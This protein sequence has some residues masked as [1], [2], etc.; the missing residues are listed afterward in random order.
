[1]T[2]N[3]SSFAKLLT[4]TSD[5][6]LNNLALKAK[7]LT[8]QH[9]GNTI[10]LYIPLYLSNECCNSCLYCGF[11]KNQKIKRQTL[12]LEEATS[13][14][15]IIKSKGFDNILLLT[16]E[17]KASVGVDYLE[18]IIQQ[19]QKMFS[20]VAL[21]V[22]PC[23]TAEYKKLVDA[24]TSGLTIYQETY[25]R[26]IYSN[27]HPAGP[28]RDFDFRFTAPERA[29]T[30]GMRKMGLGFLLGLSDW[31]TEAI[32]L[33]EHLDY[34][35]KKYWKADFTVSFPRIHEA[36]NG[37]PIQAVS[38][39][40][41]VQMILAFRIAFPKVGILLSTRENA[42]LRDNLLGLGVTQIS[43]ESKTNPGGYSEN[44]SDEQFKVS[45]NRSLEEIISTLEK[46]GFDP[47]IKDWSTILSKKQ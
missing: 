9:F 23:T 30:A 42:Q 22:F 37:L 17:H 41:F 38:D 27:M 35:M 11:N 43:A 16:G 12:S 29:L 20:Y 40:D 10:Q 46:K 36:P 24:G 14:L 34:L 31:Q 25:N 39:R 6:E 18:P 44:S 19:A 32:N 21:E 28:K 1:M 3:V 13:Q 47:V 33:A 15:Q 8:Q 4:A 45:D 7:K 5:S 2:F 26:K